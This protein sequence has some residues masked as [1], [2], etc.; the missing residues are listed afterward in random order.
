MAAGRFPPAVR[1]T[2]VTRS[3][4]QTRR[5]GEWFGR[6]VSAPM[7]F[8]LVGYLGSGK[9]IFVQ[10]LARGLEVPA[11]YYVTSPS[12]TLINEYPGRRPL[13]HIDLYRL[14]ADLDP[15]ELGLTDILKS[16]GVAAIEWADKLPA[17]AASDRIEVRFEI[18]EGDRRTLLFLAYGQEPASLLKA[19]NSQGGFEWA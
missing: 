15:D 6:H 13:A 9:T 7:V 3:E 4:E 11:G 17:Q 12:F 1:L 18:G 5:L 8:A 19:I 10:G 16:D 2:C 14:D